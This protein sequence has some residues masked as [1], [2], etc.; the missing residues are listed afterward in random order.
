MTPATRATVFL[1]LLIAAAHVYRLILG[2]QITVGGMAVPMWVSVVVI[3]VPVALAT[4]LWRE[5]RH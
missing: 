3:V 2:V 5:R 4:L 1:L